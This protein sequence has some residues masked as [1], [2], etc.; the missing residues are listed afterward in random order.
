M[1]RTIMTRTTFAL[2]CGLCVTVAASGQATSDS[3]AVKTVAEPLETEG[4]GGAR[5]F[6]DVSE[7]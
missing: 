3:L 6:G 2:L 5:G 4:Q 7:S 1:P